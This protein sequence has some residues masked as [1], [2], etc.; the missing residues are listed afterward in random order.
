MKIRKNVSIDEIKDLIAMVHVLAEKKVG[1]DNILF[2]V[3]HDLVGFVGR[4]K[5]DKYFVPRS[6]GY[7]APAKEAANEKSEGN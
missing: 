6:Y 1:S 2:N 5:G 7:R 3:V 4:S